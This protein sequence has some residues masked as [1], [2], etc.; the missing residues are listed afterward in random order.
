MPDQ[1]SR[2]PEADRRA[3]YLRNAREV[4]RL[5]NSAPTRETRA[6]FLKIAAFWDEMAKDNEPVQ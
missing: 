4:R 1:R 2:E 5:G 6:A 3:R